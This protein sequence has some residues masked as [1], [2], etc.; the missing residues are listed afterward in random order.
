MNTSRHGYFQS[1]AEELRSQSSRIRQL[2]GDT[3]IPQRVKKSVG[4]PA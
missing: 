3:A 1:L 2:I 4:L